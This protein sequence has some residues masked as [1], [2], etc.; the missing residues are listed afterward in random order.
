[1][2]ATTPEPLSIGAIAKRY[3]VST[4][5]VRSLFLTGLL[6]EP[7]RF[8]PHRIFF[9]TDLPKIEAALRQRGYLPAEEGGPLDAA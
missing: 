6:P 3:G 8:G 9:T 2:S 7:R 1:M 4:W 5:K